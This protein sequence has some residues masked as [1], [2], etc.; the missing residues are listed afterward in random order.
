MQNQNPGDLFATD[1]NP[2]GWL[3]NLVLLS[4]KKKKKKGK[5]GT[6]Y[7]VKLFMCNAEVIDWSIILNFL[8]IS[9][10]AT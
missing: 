9:N 3:C 10:I 4:H 8:L 6:S 7:F 2:K 5:E 1:P